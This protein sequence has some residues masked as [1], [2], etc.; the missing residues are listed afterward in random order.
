M[1]IMKS[2]TIDGVTNNIQGVKEI[3]NQKTI[4]LPANTSTIGA[5]ITI[6]EPGVYMIESHFTMPTGASTGA[7]TRTA[8]TT[9]DKTGNIAMHRV[10]NASNANFNWVQ[11]GI[12]YTLDDTPHTIEAQPYSSQAANNTVTSVIA[13]KIISL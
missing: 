7:T 5:Q 10:V 1:A 13:K 11:T 9:Y 2:L 6:S 3:V 8:R 4:N 12:F